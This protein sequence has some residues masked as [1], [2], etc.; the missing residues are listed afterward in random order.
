MVE[1]REIVRAKGE[2]ANDAVSCRRRKRVERNVERADALAIAKQQYR[3]E[4]R[5]V[6]RLRDGEVRA[7]FVRDVDVGRHARLEVH[8]RLAQEVPR[9]CCERHLVR[10]APA[11]DD[12][13]VARRD[14][15]GVRRTE[16]RG[17][18]E[19]RNRRDRARR[20]D[21]LGRVG[22][23]QSG[24]QTRDVDDRR[25]DHRNDEPSS[26]DAVAAGARAVRIGHDH[27]QA[28]RQHQ[29]VLPAMIERRLRNDVLRD[30][31]PDREQPGPDGGDAP[32]HL[33]AG[34]TAARICS[35][36]IAPSMPR[37]TRPSRPTITLVGNPIPRYVRP[38]CCCSSTKIGN[39]TP[40]SRA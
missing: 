4:E 14:R 24:G 8:Q 29:R 15:A 36:V 38:Y 13:R 17:R 28:N 7:A 40:C 35:I 20:S 27:D 26:G 16:E 34:A 2:R 23:E 30:D 12:P 32:G 39:V 33:S 6:G 21:H 10:I 9:R 25:A 11:Q 22:A 37:T 19:R 5:R 3:R 1:L 18:G 31:Q